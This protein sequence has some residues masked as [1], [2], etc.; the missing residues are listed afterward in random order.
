MIPFGGGLRGWLS[1]DPE[2]DLSGGHRRV[3]EYFLPGKAEHDECL[4]QSVCRLWNA[5]GLSF[6]LV[7]GDFDPERVAADVCGLGHSVT[8]PSRRDK[9]GLEGFGES[10]CLDV[11]HAAD[12]AD[13]LSAKRGERLYERVS[14]SGGKLS[15]GRFSLKSAGLPFGLYLFLT[16]LT[17][18]AV[19]LGGW[20]GLQRN[21]RQP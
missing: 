18:A 5:S 4:H 20:M 1:A 11:I 17:F 2:V 15:I 14:L 10:A 6:R 13:F 19:M 7:D 3:G 8:V 12:D 9:H 21:L 16:V